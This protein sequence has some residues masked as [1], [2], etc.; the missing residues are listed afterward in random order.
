MK[1]TISVVACVAFLTAC[2]ESASSDAA[3]RAAVSSG[4]VDPRVTDQ[5]GIAPGLYG[6]GQDDGVAFD[7]AGRNASGQPVN[8]VV[9]CGLV[10]KGCTVRWK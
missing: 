4:I 9:Y 5:H 2:G 8:A 1:K 6:C 7:I 10:L 3:I